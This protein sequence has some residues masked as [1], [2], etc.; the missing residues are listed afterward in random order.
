MH[1]SSS[2]EWCFKPGH[3]RLRS[4]QALIPNTQLVMYDK[5]PVL[6]DPKSF[7]H[8]SLCIPTIP[9]SRKL[10]LRKQWVIR[11]EWGL[12]QFWLANYFR[13]YTNNVDQDLLCILRHSVAV[14]GEAGAV[15]RIS[16]TRK[17]KRRRVMVK[18]H[19]SGTLTMCAPPK[20]RQRTMDF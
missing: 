18:F 6:A 15:F 8:L 2:T 20:K 16:G 10:A 17:G 9:Q 14:G 4:Y 13:F 12:I 3:S 7:L 19:A 5:H 1:L 11:P